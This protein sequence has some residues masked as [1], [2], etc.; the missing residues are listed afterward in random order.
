MKSRTAGTRFVALLSLAVVASLVPAPVHA[1]ADSEKALFGPIGVVPG[2]VV[3]FNVHAIGD[4]NEAPWVFVVRVLDSQGNLVKESRLERAPGR[5]GSADF[6]L[7]DLGPIPP[8]SHGRRTLRAEIAGFNPQPDPP[9]I[10][11]TT[12]E[13]FG[14]FGVTTVYGPEPHLVPNPAQ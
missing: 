8:D 10:W 14:L 5:I 2:Q 13:V 3:R 6:T 12:L 11:F 4:P 9:G 1:L 7:R